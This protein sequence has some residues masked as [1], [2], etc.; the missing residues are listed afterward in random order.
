M[1]TEFFNDQW[2][3]PSNENQNK[4]SK[5]SM[6]FDGTSSIIDISGIS[7]SLSSSGTGTFSGWLKWDGTSVIRVATFSSNSVDRQYIIIIVR[8][9]G[10]AYAQL[11]DS[12]QLITSSAVFT[13]NVWTH[14]VV[15]HNGTAAKFYIN[16]SVPLQG[17]T[18]QTNKTHWWSHLSTFNNVNIGA[19]TWSNGN[20]N[21]TINYG[22]GVIAQ[23]TIFDYALLDTEVSTLYGDGTAVVNPMTLSPKPVYYAQLG[24]QS[25]D[26]GA[27][28]LV[29]NNSLSG[30]EGYSPYA[31]D[32]DGVNDYLDCG[33]SNTFSFGNGTTDSPF[34]LSGWVNPDSTA[35]FRF[36]Y[37][38]NGTNA[39][40]ICA[41]DSSSKLTFSLYNNGGNSDRIG[42]KV[43]VAIT[44]GWQHWTFTYDGT[45]STDDNSGMK[46]YINGVEAGSYTSS[47]VGSYTAMNNTNVNLEIG[48]ATYTSSYANGKISNVSIFNTELTSTQVTEIYNQGV[49]SN[50]NNFSGTA[51]VAW[52]QLGSNSSY[53]SGAW[54]CLDE[55]G[56]N[57]A[58][59]AGSMTNDDIVDGPGYSAS[60][61][62]TSSIDIKG[63][64]PYSKANGLSEN[65]D[66]LDR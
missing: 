6:E 37:K 23:V 61:L 54:T 56:T 26:N 34:S 58:V 27:N 22:A 57:N 65:M 9:D 28:Y 29:P 1:S 14:F 66:V 55:I 19:M 47:N 46:M 59:S 21:P 51:P 10:K 43:N 45:G 35:Q 12:W 3:I 38:I 40:Y 20:N 60:G 48:A 8:S 39:E 4:V 62:G 5:Y 13:A 36:M 24:D 42:K 44:T 49:P 63:D 7:S 16:G 41:T 52:W 18:Q 32:F 31:L 17:F 30:S 64:A 50:L 53:N 33:D 11:K 25:V 15:A 2:R